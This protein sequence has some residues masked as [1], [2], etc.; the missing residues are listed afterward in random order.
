MEPK[1][2]NC[3]ATEEVSQKEV[4]FKDSPQP[5]KN[6]TKAII[7]NGKDSTKTE[8][9]QENSIKCEN[10]NGITAKNRGV[11]VLPPRFQ[12]L[13]LNTNTSKD[14]SVVEK[15]NESTPLNRNE[16]LN[17]NGEAAKHDQDQTLIDEPIKYR[18]RKD[19]LNSEND[20]ALFNRL[21]AY[22]Y[23]PLCRLRVNHR[24]F[25]GEVCACLPYS[26]VGRIFIY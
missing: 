18:L 23:Q 15:S 14:G 13:L 10:I 12:A 20:E 6:D 19:V 7:T 9:K 17:R 16:T 24:Q 1:V 2:G 25:H 26:K 4:Q 5:E 22:K 11:I 3:I 21:S 8:N